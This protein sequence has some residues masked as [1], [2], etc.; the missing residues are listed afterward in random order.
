MKA[1]ESLQPADELFFSQQSID[2]YQ[3]DVDCEP[4]SVNQ[5]C[6][7]REVYVDDVCIYADLLVEHVNYSAECRDES[8]NDLDYGARPVPRVHCPVFS[9]R[10]RVGISSIFGLI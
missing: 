5:P 10:F 7:S 3:R 1:D 4:Y 9:I 8:A 6:V 2:L